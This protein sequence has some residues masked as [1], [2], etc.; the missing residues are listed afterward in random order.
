MRSARR[1]EMG[2]PRSFP[3]RLSTVDCGLST[4]F[5]PDLLSG[6]DEVKTRLRR[7]PGQLFPVAAVVSDLRL[8]ES[9]ELGQVPGDR[10][11]LVVHDLP[12][13]LLF[14]DQVEGAGQQGLL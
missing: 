8:V 1:W 9:H 4:L 10:I 2:R 3:L 12:A 5:Q 6:R 7:L 13:V 14:E 11:G